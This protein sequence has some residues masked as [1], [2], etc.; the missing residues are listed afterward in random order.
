VI[1]FS[2]ESKHDPD[3]FRN[4]LNGILPEDIRVLTA[5]HTR[6]DFH[7]RYDATSK[8]YLYH[9]ETGPRNPF[10][11]RYCYH[12]GSRIDVG[13][14]VE[15]SRYLIGEKDFSSFRASGC[16]SR[17]PVREIYSL[18]IREMTEIGFLTFG[19]RG[20]FISISIH[21]NAFLRHMARNIVGTLIEIGRKRLEPDDINMIIEGRDRRLAGPSAPARGLFLE[22]VYYNDTCRRLRRGR[23]QEQ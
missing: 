15:A 11:Q 21:A 1:S 20:R 8:K 3:V 23:R 6:D 17:T 5:E 14:M 19:F 18:D 16:G 2:T 4:A 9:I 7:P 10:L 12:T 13:R 22:K